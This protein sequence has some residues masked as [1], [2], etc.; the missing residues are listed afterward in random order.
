MSTAYPTLTRKNYVNGILSG[1]TWGID[2]TIIALALYY[3]PF[4]HDTKL[5]LGA[6]FI[7]CLIHI[8]FETIFM[9]TVVG[10]HHTWRELREAW[11]QRGTWIQ[12]LGSV[13]GGP[14]SM[15]CYLL[16][17]DMTG[18]DITT[19]VTDCYPFIGAIMAVYFLREKVPV[20]VWFG[21]LLC[22]FGIFYSGMYIEESAKSTNLYGIL[23]A[24][25]PALGWGFEG[26]ACRYALHKCGMHP[27]I[28]LWIREISCLVAYVAIAPLLLGSMDHVTDIIMTL[29]NYKGA[30]LLIIIASGFAAY[31]M[32]LWYQT[33]Q[34]MG[35]ARGLCLNASYCVWT[36][37]FTSVAF[38]QM[39]DT[40]VWAGAAMTA[41]G[42]AVAIWPNALGARRRPVA[43]KF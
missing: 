43:D 36:L 37:L 8:F 18:S 4:F 19:T 16:A 10:L 25:V 42:I 13:C 22:I 3:T 2:T 40:N 21:I 38:V 29:A 27:H 26:V 32:L 12:I 31:S 30:F 14:V 23:L 35:A 34:V 15:M 33:I 9:S 28:A 24:L 41:F 1:V 6:T 39:P 7:C 20:Q 5:L 11:S 17:I